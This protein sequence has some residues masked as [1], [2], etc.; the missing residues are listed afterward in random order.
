MT[1]PT[2]TGFDQ[3]WLPVPVPVVTHTRA[4]HYLRLFPTYVSFPLAYPST[5]SIGSA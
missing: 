2:G 1:R 3:I 4:H 5:E